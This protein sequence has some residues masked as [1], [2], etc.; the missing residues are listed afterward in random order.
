MERGS[1][2]LAG[3]SFEVAL[4]KAATKGGRFCFKVEPFQTS[5]E[6][7]FIDGQLVSDEQ[8]WGTLEK[9]LMLL[10]FG[11]SGSFRRLAESP[12]LNAR[13]ESLVAW[14]WAWRQAKRR[15]DTL[16]NVLASADIDPDQS[17]RPNHAQMMSVRELPDPV[18]QV[19][20]SVDGQ[21]TA[22]ELV[23]FGP[24]APELVANVLTDLVKDG[25]VEP[26]P[27]QT[28]ELVS[29]VPPSPTL[30]RHDMRLSLS[31]T[32]EVYSVVPAKPESSVQLSYWFGWLAILALLMGIFGAIWISY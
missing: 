27:L 21:R 5:V 13:T 8:N 10:A 32:A 12:E 26:V 2:P 6:L 17:L 4:T 18:V 14:N 25:L 20:R 11:T 31:S 24:H 30:N 9:Q 16:S 23:A 22:A 15:V 1:E 7:T 29:S 28:P 3:T 19:L